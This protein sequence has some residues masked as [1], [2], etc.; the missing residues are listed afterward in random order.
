MKF[1]DTKCLRKAEKSEEGAGKTGRNYMNKYSII[2]PLMIY[3]FFKI[4]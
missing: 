2:S 1:F 3:V 4:I